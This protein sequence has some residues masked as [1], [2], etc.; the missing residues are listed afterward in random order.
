MHRVSLQFAGLLFLLSFAMPSAAATQEHFATPFKTRNMS[1]V[2]QIFG[3]PAPQGGQLT[4]AGRAEMTLALE[5]ANNFTWDKADGESVWFDGE[6][7]RASLFFNYG[8]AP[9]WEFGLEVPLISHNTGIFDSFIEGWHDAFGLPQNGRKDTP[10]RQL[11]YTY[12]RNGS[13]PELD[14]GDTGTGIGDLSLHL[15]YQLIADSPGNRRALSLRAGV[16][17]PTGDSDR[18]RGSGATDVH[19]RLAL[20]DAESLGRYN[21]TLFASG[22]ILWLAEGDV[23]S[24]QQRDFVEF[25][26][27]G[28]DW[29]P[30]PVLSFKLQVDGHS[31]FYRD[32]N[33]DQ[34]DSPSAQLAMGG[35]V[36]FTEVDTIDLCVTEDIMVDTA[37]DVVFHVAWNHRF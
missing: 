22:G 29:R 23:L 21:L 1:P 35:T 18:L 30:W 7:S 34:I 28:L 3:L 16:K 33:L 14:M 25:G 12:E 19:L 37:S 11:D 27:V 17:L 26:S 5:T 2:I 20:T 8:I 13:S 4:P 15:G 6:T 36:Y 10:R 24:D 9:N 32:S 31:S